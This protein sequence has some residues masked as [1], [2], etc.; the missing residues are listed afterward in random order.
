MGGGDWNANRYYICFIKN[1]LTQ[2]YKQHDCTTPD[3]PLVNFSK[4]LNN[5]NNNY[6]N[7]YNTYNNSNNN[8]N[9]NNNNNKAE[10]YNRNNMYKTY[11]Q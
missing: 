9:N 10:L 5:N 3:E 4:K 11:L 1:K 7:N 8:N 2:D 6:N